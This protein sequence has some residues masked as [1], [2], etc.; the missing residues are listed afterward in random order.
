MITPQLRPA[1]RLAM[2]G[3]L[4]G[5]SACSLA[6]DAP[7]GQP[8]SPDILLGPLFNDVQSAKLFPDQKTFADAVPKSDPLMIL[9]D[10][11]MQRNQSGF[12]LRHFVDMNFTLPKAGEKYVP[13]AGQSL[14]EHI[15]GLWPVL[16]RTTDTAGKWD[17][18]LPLP[19]PYVVPGGRFRE[20]YYWD[21]YFTML[22]LAQSGHWDKIADMVANFGHEI[23]AWGHIPNGNRSYYLSRSQPPFFSL[24]VELLATHD[25]E[26][27]KQYRPQM[28]K[29]HAY[30][31][32]GVDALQP[33]QANQ[34]VVKLEDGSILN[35]YWDDRD[36]PRPESWMDDVTTAK[37]NPD[38]PATEIYRD[39]R[40]AAASGWDF[41]SRWM[42]DPKKLGTIRTTSIVPVDLNALMFKMEKLLAK[43]SQEAGDS[44]AASKYDGLA[45]A[46]Q[47]AMESHLWNDKE[48]WYADYDLKTKKVRNQLT[49]AALFPLYVNAAAQDRAD[50]VAKATASRL[51]KPGGITTTT[52]NSGQQWDAP[53]GWAPLQWV[54]TEG[55][56][57]YGHKKVA[58]D[59]TWRF[60]TNVQHTYD[61]EKK[62]VEKYDVSTTGTGG[63]GGEYPLQDGFGW[64]NGV[65]LQ[66]LSLVCPKEKPC[67]SLPANQ[68]AANDEP[69]PQAQAAQ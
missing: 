5:F 50:K 15:D 9:A 53:N 13:P 11:R 29:E 43:A 34:R 32:E 63:G 38:R 62:L 3:I 12:D 28:E 44:A 56:Q 30:W 49:A 7:A 16:T 51:L 2:G 68:P 31:M 18:L 17:S 60:L 36:T 21:S 67:D 39:L 48:G 47:K 8:Q 65:T 25:P 54:A 24:M 45:S 66:M 69:A 1:L 57:N 10:Y 41:S 26:A 42:D 64:T 40:S 27:L 52:V 46:R 19:K 59:V 55:L 35:R 4:L 20:V 58:M 61:R 22:G 23:D 14:R 37:N 6:D 33:G